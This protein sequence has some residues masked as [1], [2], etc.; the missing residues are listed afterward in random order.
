MNFIDKLK[1]QVKK[2]DGKIILP[3]ANLDKRVMTACVEIVENKLSKV[4]VLGKNKD[5]DMRLR[6]NP[7][8]EIIDI[9][10]Y[11]KLNA[12]AKKLYELR[13]EKGMTLDDAEKLVKTPEYFSC[14]LLKT[15]V[16]DGMVAGA[17]WTTANTLR[18]VLQII[19]AKKGRDFVTGSSLLVKDNEKPVL[20]GDMAIV[21]D[22][23]AEELS[24][25]AVSNADFMKKVL[26]ID[27]KVA[28]LSFSTAGSGVGEVVEK[29]RKATKFCEKS[30]YDIFGEI[31]FDAA[32]NKLVA[33]RKKLDNEVA[34]KA[35]VF[36][37]P[38]LNAG[39]IATK[40]A[41]HMGG[42][43]AIG[44]VLINLNKPMSDL[45]RGTDVDEI[46]YTVCL[47]KL[48]KNA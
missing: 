8:C 9:D 45:S 4:V 18:P 35:N 47:T 29:V 20:F 6:N 36:I 32:F 19:K 16:V 28:L 26:N 33:K 42:Y 37:F 39:N 5:F 24:K 34:G 21:K 41:E 10:T 48:M 7:L 40:I 27:P 30:K 15:G 44:P 2:I 12:L 23:S 14:M 31:Q 22:P 25:I 38:D 43:K 13:K 1:L 11:P 46:I 17:V 3:E